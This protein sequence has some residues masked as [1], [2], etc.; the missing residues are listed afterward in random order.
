MKK[1]LLLIAIVC[2][3]MIHKQT[4]AQNYPDN[5]T[6]YYQTAETISYPVIEFNYQQLEVSG[7]TIIN[8][9]VFK[10]VDKIGLIAYVISGTEYNREYIRKDDD[11]V[12]WFNRD[13][14]EITLLYDFG[15]GT[16]ETWEVTVYDCPI[17][18]TVDSVN[19]SDYNGIQIKNQFVSDE[20]GYFSGK[21]IDGIGH[22]SSFFPNE[23]Y[24]LCKYGNS[25][26]GIYIDGIR[27]YSDASGNNYSFMNMP[28]DTIYTQLI[29]D[30][31][32]FS[33]QAANIELYPN[34]ATDKI[35]IKYGDNTCSR[36]CIMTATGR[37]LKTFNSAAVEID[38]KDLP[39]GIY[40]VQI[41]CDNNIFT[42]K[43]LINR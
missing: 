27:C 28:C 2:L 7:D 18:V 1:I 30:I 34:P 15:A 33:P 10:I 37:L 24:Y 11:K 43:L 9:E 35:S 17:T 8:G 13:T 4:D 19:Y 36:V 5:T 41:I 39:D 21:I 25:P 29:N 32:E 12:Y 31:E 26:D 42:Q 3:F 16:G 40:L 22:S 20:N 38:T 14:E 23:I 6:W